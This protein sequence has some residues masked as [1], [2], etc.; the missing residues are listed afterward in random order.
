MTTTKHEIKNCPNCQKSFECRSGDII[1]CQ[2]EGIELKQHHRDYIYKTWNDC[3]CIDCLNAIRSECDSQHF[4]KK[5]DR[6]V[7]HR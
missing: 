5:I 4:L 1:Q 6:L 7:Q 2:C 3:L